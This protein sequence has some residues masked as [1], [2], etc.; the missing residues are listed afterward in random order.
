M[1]DVVSIGTG[2]RD[3]YL[4][5]SLFKVV[6]DKKHLQKMGFALGEATCFALGS[7]TED[8]KSVV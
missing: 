8:R 1:L 6:K 2:T 3:V 4:I 7:K 5:D